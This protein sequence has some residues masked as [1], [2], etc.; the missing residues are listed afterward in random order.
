[1]NGP[2]DFIGFSLA[3]GGYLLSAALIIYGIFNL[4]F[5]GRTHKRHTKKIMHLGKVI[6]PILILMAAVVLFFINLMLGWG[7]A[8]SIALA[9]DVA[10]LLGIILI[11]AERRR[12]YGKRIQEKLQNKFG[13]KKGVFII[14][15]TI[16]ILLAILILPNL[17]IDNLRPAYVKGP[18]GIRR[19]VYY[20][21][22]EP[23]YQFSGMSVEETHRRYK[24]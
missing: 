21:D 20:V 9:I 5:T 17:D 14:I 16:V 1:L 8:G 19:S 23:F 4:V 24:F 13:R 10:L 11:T 7:G 15:A 6:A 12:G 18:D 3:L 2:K 22:G